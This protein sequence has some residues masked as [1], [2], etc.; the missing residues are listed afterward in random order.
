MHLEGTSVLRLSTCKGR[1]AAFP[2]T[3]GCR[4]SLRPGPAALAGCSNSMN[5]SPH[6]FFAGIQSCTLENA[7]KGGNSQA[8]I[9]EARRKG[10]RTFL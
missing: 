9:P 7:P 4:A 2:P 3:H 6:F 5:S 8:V 1:A 10:D